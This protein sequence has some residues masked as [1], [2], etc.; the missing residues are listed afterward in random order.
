MATKKK[1]PASAKYQLPIDQVMVAIDLR[2]GNYYDKLDDDGRKALST[3]MAQRWASQVQCT[4]DVQEQYLIDVNAYSNIDYI[5]T[6]S[7]HE[8]LRWRA[9][10]LVGLGVKLRHEFIPPIGVKKDKLTAWLIE[11][12]PQLGTEEIEL[13]REI[14]SKDVL[15]DIARTQNMGN[16]E[17]K[18]L[19]K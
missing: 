7:A 4:R 17:L 18:E 9:L 13:F 6:T 10:A 11:K 2:K 8:E 1:E 16:K 14:N 3:Y 15:E 12:F 19:F 5:A